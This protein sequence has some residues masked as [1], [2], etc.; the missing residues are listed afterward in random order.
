MVD[1]F[2]NTLDPKT[3]A[4]VTVSKNKVVDIVATA[5]A[6]AVIKGDHLVARIQCLGQVSTCRTHQTKADARL[7][8][9]NV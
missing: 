9:C 3:W 6:E 7:Q 1:G 4:Y 5:A 8:T 2:R